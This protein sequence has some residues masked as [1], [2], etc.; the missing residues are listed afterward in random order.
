[1]LESYLKNSLLFALYT[2]LPLIYR[3]SA[4]RKVASTIARW[5][6]HSLIHRAII[7]YLDKRSYAKYTLTYRFLSFFAGKLDTLAGGAHGLLHSARQSS[8]F[9][10]LY[11]DTSAASKRKPNVLGSISAAS[12]ILGY[13]I[14]ITIRGMWSPS[15]LLYVLVIGI[16]A[17]VIA[18][19]ADRWKSWIRHSTFYRLCKYIWE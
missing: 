18:A 13:T 9:C 19:S 10:R 12:F 11:D 4:V 15:N 16:F 14:I 7:R 2:R 17:A 1:M 8:S 3:Q 6:S 5:Y